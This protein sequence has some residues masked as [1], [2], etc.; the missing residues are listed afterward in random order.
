MNILIPAAPIDAVELKHCWIINII[1]VQY[2]YV[3]AQ[4]VF[5]A[6]VSR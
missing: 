2:V 5:G 3:A 4:S 1:A 6:L